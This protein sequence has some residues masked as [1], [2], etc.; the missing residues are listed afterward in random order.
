MKNSIYFIFFFIVLIFQTCI[1]RTK[2]VELLGKYCNSNGDSF[3]DY[4]RL[5]LEKNSFYTYSATSIDGM[6]FSC[7]S[8]EIVNNSVI[9]NSG[10]SLFDFI[11]QK[12]KATSSDSIIFNF[13]EN[14]FKHQDLQNLKIDFDGIR[15]KAKQR[16]AISKADLIQEAKK[17]DIHLSEAKIFNEKFYTF[18]FGSILEDDEINISF[19][20]GTSLKQRKW[21]FAK[22]KIKSDGLKS[23][24]STDLYSNKHKLMRCD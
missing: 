3:E 22:Y 2:E 16:T 10:N 17:R 5:I 18:T 24:Y 7:G 19:R 14:F 4:K 21:V 15:Y 23:N 11:N 6:L 20:E 9:L 13:S 1:K 8:W 12:A